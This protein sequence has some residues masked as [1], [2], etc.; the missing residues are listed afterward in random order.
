MW[1]EIVTLFSEMGTLSIIFLSIGAILSII[2]AVIP[3][4]GIF[5][6]M[7]IIM[8]VVGIVF[9]VVAGASLLQVFILV[10][11]FIGFILLLLLVLTYSARSGLLSKTGL[12]EK[13][14]TIRRDWASD[15]ANYAY[16][17]GKEGVT[18]TA[19]KPVGKVLIDNLTYQI[20]SDGPYIPK[21]SYVKVIEVDGVNIIVRK[22]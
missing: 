13:S 22:I 1:N 2:E 20:F 8:T 19:C 21:G 14:S 3:G 16:L 9:R 12:V 17:L 11:L 10:G 15:E 7:G 6:V 5:G 18:Q 4:F